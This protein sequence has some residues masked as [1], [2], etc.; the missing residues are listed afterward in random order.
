MAGDAV[1]PAHGEGIGAAFLQLAD[2]LE[3]S[4]PV[5]PPGRVRLGVLDIGEA[6]VHHNEAYANIR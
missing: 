3:P 1:G 5:P 4:R 2:P 6:H